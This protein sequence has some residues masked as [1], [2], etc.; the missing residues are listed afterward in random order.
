MSRLK[1]LT[2]ALALTA[3]ACGSSDSGN[4]TTPTIPTVTDTYSESLTKNDAVT[5][6]FVTS[7]SGPVTATLTTLA[8]DSTLVVGLALGT[9]NGTACQVVLANDKATQGSVVDAQ[10]STS[11]NLCVRVYDVGNVTTPTTFEVQ[12]VHY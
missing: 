7:Q 11:G 2:V 10:A 5:K 3:A 9:W 8:P 6:S 1:Y 12:V 4:P